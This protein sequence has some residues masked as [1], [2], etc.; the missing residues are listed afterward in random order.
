MSG[1][2]SSSKLLEF[3]KKSNKSRKVDM[4]PSTDINC[5]VTPTELNA[6]EISVVLLVQIYNTLQ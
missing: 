2:Y 3:T 6:L 4:I 1:L 5:V